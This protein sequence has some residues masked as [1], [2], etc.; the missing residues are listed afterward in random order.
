MALTDLFHAARRAL[1]PT[2][3]QEV[4]A[5]LQ[6]A[7]QPSGAALGVLEPGLAYLESAGRLDDPGALACLLEA[8]DVPA[9]WQ[10]LDRR[11]GALV[12]V[13]WHFL[14]QRQ[15]RGWQS[16]AAARALLQ[17]QVLAAE[18]GLSALPEPLRARALALRRALGAD[19]PLAAWTSPWVLAPRPRRSSPV[20]AVAPQPWPDRFVHLV[21]PES[22]PERAPAEDARLA[23]LVRRRY[24]GGRLLWPLLRMSDAAALEVWT[25]LRAD[26]VQVWGQELEL[27]IPRL[28]L[29]GLD[30]SLELVRAHRAGLPGLKD[31]DSPRVAPLMA[32]HL[33]GKPTQRAVAR[34]WLG[35]FPEAAAV[36]LVAPALGA[37][38]EA[39]A[40]AREALRWLLQQHG[41][42]A[43]RGLAR[44][45]DEVRQAL[46]AALSE[47]GEL[48]TRR[49]RLPA[50][51]DPRYLPRPVLLDGSAALGG[52]ALLELVRLVAASP[53]RGGPWL[54]A[55]RAEFQPE[56]LQALAWALFQAWLAHG[57]SP[58]ERW[59]LY[60][61]AHF[62]APA[63]AE[64]LALLAADL[65][66]R[67]FSARAQE[68]VEVLAA[69]GTREGLL[70]VQRLSRG[71][72]ARAF[73]ARAELVFQAAAE[74]Q[75]FCE[76]E[77][78][79]RLAPDLGLSPEGWLPGL[80]RR[81][82]AVLPRVQVRLLDEAGRPISPPATGADELAVLKRQA[83]AVLRD[84]AARLEARMALGRSMTVEHFTETYLMH[85]LLR[86]LA[87][88]VV[89]GALEGER[90]A[91]TF[92]VGARG[93]EDVRGAPV[94][95]PPGQ[96][97]VVVVY[98]AHLSEAER[99]AW[100]VRLPD[101]PFVQLRRHGLVPGSPGELVVRLG[102]LE[103]RELQTGGLVRLRAWGW[104]PA[105]G[106]EGDEGHHLV[107][108]AGDFGV[109]ELSVE[110]GGRPGDPVRSAI[111]QVRRVRV[112]L[113]P[114]TPRSLLGEVEWE[115]VQ[116]LRG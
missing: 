50:W 18:P 39:R 108:R 59:A 114:D 3:A 72:L 112:L 57:A 60:A 90:L 19:L 2:P 33:T 30:V 26:E 64:G 83:E 31:L 102:A 110:P 12:E 35:R 47:V 74:A 86:A 96:A 84:G 23:D 109:V 27:L 20:I 24:P 65:A 62:P 34:G 14:E 52:E 113:R 13:A 88:G 91:V 115:L 98:P 116:A 9:V 40:H 38:A 5:L 73:R 56:T 8:A 28:G 51:V 80:P 104:Q 100:A 17:R 111:Q 45:S 11:G 67:G 55:V 10:A 46:E 37:E 48:P 68:M 81:R 61:L 97:V 77:L 79:E 85:P 103:G 87:G 21:S 107:R 44:F 53:L 75:G 32:P 63:A 42:A 7:F 92:T 1:R 99:A 66:P 76:E 71:V 54:Q 15:G 101:Q 69:M 41:E 94:P 29:P 49:P 16:Q 36:G 106:G 6:R 22:I 70:A 25:S 105:R 78:A 93:P 89:W 95:L 43:R 4:Q 82:L 58:R